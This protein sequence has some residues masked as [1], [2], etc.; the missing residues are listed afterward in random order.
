MKKKIRRIT[1]RVSK[2]GWSDVY[3]LTTG[4]TPADAIQRLGEYEDTGILPE[5]L[6]ALLG[7]LE[8]FMVAHET[9]TGN[10]KEYEEL[11]K[12]IYNEP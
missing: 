2:K 5:K 11:S 8:C 10:I 1:R 9:M 4:S 3:Y 6:Y 12:E 7:I